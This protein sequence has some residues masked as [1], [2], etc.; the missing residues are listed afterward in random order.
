MHDDNNMEAFAD[1]GRQNAL[2]ACRL[3]KFFL[4]PHLWS[5]PDLLELLIRVWNPID[6][7]FI[8]QGRDVEFDA[9]DIYLLTELSRCVE[10]PILEGQRRG[11]NSLEMLMAQ[12]CTRACKSRSGKV[13]IPTVE[14][15]V[16]HAI[17]FMVTQVEGSQVQHKPSK[18]HLRLALK[19]L[20]PTMF[21]WAEAVVANMKRQLTN[22]RRGETKQFGYG[23][24]LFPLILEWVSALQL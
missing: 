23:S 17:L 12:V 9:T 21:N 5:R 2:R 22:C 24:I 6:G 15:V 1:V 16:L 8:I 14:D 11:G 3:V 20:N 7:K 18:T 13:A 10:K 4:T 19:C